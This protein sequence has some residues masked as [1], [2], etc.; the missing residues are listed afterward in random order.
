M[1]W[2]CRAINIYSNHFIIFS[3]EPSRIL[4]WEE[5]EQHF[6]MFCK[7]LSNFQKID[8]TPVSLASPV[9]SANEMN[10]GCCYAVSHLWTWNCHGRQHGD[11]GSGEGRAS[12]REPHPRVLLSDAGHW[13]VRCPHHGVPGRFVCSK[14][15]D[16][17][18]VT[19][20]AASARAAQ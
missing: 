6:T 14:K 10:L 20:G 12:G 9:A 11:I 15:M 4:E 1:Y 5:T 18:R 7:E 17:G 19:A 2:R 8:P 13:P 3:T 16:V